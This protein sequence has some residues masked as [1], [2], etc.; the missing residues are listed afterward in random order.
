MRVLEM[1]VVL[2]DHRIGLR[3][4]CPAVRTPADRGY[5]V[6]ECTDHHEE[7]IDDP[8]GDESFPDTDRGRRLEIVDQDIRQRRADHG[9]A[10]EARDGKSRRHAAMIREPFDQRRNRRNVAEAKTDAAE[11]A[12]AEPHQPKLMDVNADRADHQAASPAQSRDNAGFARTGALKPAA[13]DR[14]R[15]AEQHKE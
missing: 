11:D 7:E 10:A 15:Y 6:A 5:P 9:A 4:W 1:D 14:S 3:R 12:G 2:R 13:P 8:H